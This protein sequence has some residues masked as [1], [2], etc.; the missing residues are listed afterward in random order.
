MKK[1]HIIFLL[2]ISGSMGLGNKI[3]ETTKG[4]EEFIKEQKSI[5]GDCKMS[6]WCFDN[7]LDQIFINKDIQE[8]PDD[9]K[10]LGTDLT[11][12]ATALIDSFCKVVDKM[13]KFFQD[14]PDSDKPE[15]VIFT[16]LTDGR[17]NC[18]LEFRKKDMLDRINHQKD[19]YNWKFAYLSDDL[20]AI[21]EAKDLGF[22]NTSFNTA[23]VGESYTRGAQINTLYRTHSSLTED[24]LNKKLEDS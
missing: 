7:K 19:N 18:S 14:Q 13:G 11:R 6:L 12:G 8:V 22:A 9:I 17:E 4:W 23:S 10:E 24:E 21:T 5:K 3:E 1:T 16:T 2:D 15:L 20:S